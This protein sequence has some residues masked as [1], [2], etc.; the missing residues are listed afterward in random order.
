MD[1]RYAAH[2]QSLSAGRTLPN[3]GRVCRADP[4]GHHCHG[5]FGRTKRPGPLFQEVPAMARRVRLVALRIIRHPD[6]AQYSCIP[7]PWHFHLDRILQQHRVDPLH[8][9]AHIAGRCDPWAAVGRARLARVCPAAPAE[10]VWANRWHA[11]P[12]CFVGALAPSRL[13]GGLDDRGDRST[14][15]FRGGIFDHCHLGL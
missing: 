15:P 14:H 9:S 2:S 3:A 6:R 13:P 10:P 4:L 12:G 11:D 8:L 7:Y 5:G 1:C